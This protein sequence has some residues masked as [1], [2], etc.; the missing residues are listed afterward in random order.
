MKDES[1]IHC[2]AVVSLAGL[3]DQS[4][5]PALLASLKDVAPEVRYHA[6]SGLGKLNAEKAVRA[7]RE[8]LEDKDDMVRLGAKQSLQNLGYKKRCCASLTTNDE[9]CN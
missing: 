6:V 3:G 9:S 4:V 5:I 2:A 1:A 8:M 7:I